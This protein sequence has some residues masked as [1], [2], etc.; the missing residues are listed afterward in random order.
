MRFGNVVA[1]WY[2]LM[3][4]QKKLTFFTA[5]YSQAAVVFPFIMVSPAYFS[6]AMQLGGLMQTANAFG[7][8]QSALSVSSPS[9]AASPNGARSSSDCTA[10]S[11]RSR[12]RAPL[13]VTPPVIEV[14][15]GDEQGRRVQGPR[16]CGCRTA[17]RW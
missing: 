17:C 7:Q 1:N 6:G 3:T 16:R 13:S 12:A 10:S 11:S 5:S 15:R 14:A 2:A 8:V 9:I 4:R